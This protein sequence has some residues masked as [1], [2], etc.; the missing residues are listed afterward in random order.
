M[1]ITKYKL[2]KIPEGRNFIAFVPELGR[3]Y[4]ISQE[5][6]NVLPNFVTTNETTP[7]AGVEISDGIYPLGSVVLVLTNKCNLQCS[8]CYGNFGVPKSEVG[9]TMELRVA[10]S[11]IDYVLAQVLQAKKK[12]VASRSIWRRTDVSMGSDA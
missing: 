2:F 5:A 11:A 6:G 1:N 10:K 12:E 4:R 9:K 3:V 7:I 8:Y